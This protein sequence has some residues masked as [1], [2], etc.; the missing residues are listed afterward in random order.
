MAEI[1]IIENCNSMNLTLRRELSKWKMIRLFLERNSNNFIPSLLHR[2]N[3]QNNFEYL[4]DY[5]N[6]NSIVY[7]QTIIGIVT[8]VP[9]MSFSL[10]NDRSVI[11]IPYLATARNY[12][13]RGVMKR[14]LEESLSE[15]RKNPNFRL[16]NRVE[17]ET[18]STNAP[19]LNLFTKLGF[20]EVQREPNKRGNRIDNIKLVLYL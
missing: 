5:G 10:G 14:L 11:Y 2:G 18:W 9:M 7:N 3:F 12:R 16:Y 17:L 8:Y 13:R 19:A 1:G 6:A 15:I 4:K 20:K